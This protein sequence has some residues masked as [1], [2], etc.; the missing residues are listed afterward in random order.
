MFELASRQKFRFSTPNGLIS[1]EDLWDIPLTSSTNKANLDD[2][3]R[4]LYS[5]LDKSTE[6]SFV[7][8]KKKDETVQLKFDLVKHVIEVRLAENAAA[9]LAKSNRERKQEIMALIANKENQE[10]A[11]SSVEDLKALLATL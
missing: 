3:A 2:I 10:L 11:G 8:E 1:V 4:E 9:A 7:S 5:Q 6:I